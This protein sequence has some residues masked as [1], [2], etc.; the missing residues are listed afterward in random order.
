MIRDATLDDVPTIAALGELFHAEAG[1]SDIA[2]YVPADCE[3]TLAML[4]N[5]DDGILIVAEDEGAIIG[6]AGGLAHPFYFNHA[7]KTGME[8]FWWVKP[9]RRNGLGAQLL[10]AMESQ[11]NAKGCQSWA[12]IALDK[13]NPELTGRF[14]RMRGYRASEHSWIK[15]L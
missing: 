8:F 7:H 11:A 10:D 9:G 4:V 14:Y 6:M 15:R 2:E 12:M 13:V 1:W 5:S 3:K